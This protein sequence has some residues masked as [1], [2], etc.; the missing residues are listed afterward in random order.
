MANGSTIC[1]AGAVG[2]PGTVVGGVLALASPARLPG[3]RIDTRPVTINTTM[4]EMMKT[5]IRR[6]R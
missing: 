3:L 6:D 1:A 2:W 5:A 4:L